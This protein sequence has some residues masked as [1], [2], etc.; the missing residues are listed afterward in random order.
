[1]DPEIKLL[2]QHLRASSVGSNLKL[3]CKEFYSGIEKLCEEVKK[4]LESYC[5]IFFLDSENKFKDDISTKAAV[6]M[7]FEMFCDLCDVDYNNRVDTGGGP[8]DSKFSRGAYL[9]VCLD[10]K[11]ADDKEFWD[12]AKEKGLSLEHFISG[13]FSGIAGLN[14][15]GRY[16][17]FFVIA[18]YEED[19]KKKDEFEKLVREAGEAEDITLK[20]IYLDATYRPSSDSKKDFS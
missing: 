10:I 2:K 19:L 3:R 14:D 1:M 18:R 12:T 16:G 8:I 5:E 4:N 15:A 20:L 7:A 17:I 13:T 11:F 9:K 6:H